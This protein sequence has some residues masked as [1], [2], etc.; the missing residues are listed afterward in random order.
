[1][2]ERPSGFFGNFPCRLKYDSSFFAPPNPNWMPVTLHHK[3]IR[4][5][6]FHQLFQKE[7]ELEI[8]ADSL[9]L[10][11]E[12]REFLENKIRT[13]EKPIYGINTGFGQLCRKEVAEENLE[14]LQTNLVRSHACGIGAPVPE[15]I[16][17]LMLLLKIK[18]FT[19]GH[20]AISPELMETLVA[21]YNS[22]AAPVVF[23][24]GSLGASGD[25]VPLAHMTLPL[26]G[27]GEVL[28]KN[29]RISGQDFLTKTGHPPV[30][31]KAKEGL[32]MLNGTQFMLAYGLDLVWR[33]ERVMENAMAVCALAM[34]AYD[35]RIDSLDPAIHA[36][37]PHKG[38]IRVAEKLSAFLKDS[39]IATKEKHQVQDPYSFRCLP[40]VL[41]ASWDTLDYVS[42]VLE[43]ELN[44]ITDN[45]LVFKESG[46][47]ISGGNFHG[48]PLALALDFLAI[49][50][51][52]VANIAERML[53]QILSGERGLPV[54]LTKNPGL[55]SGFMIP[56]YSAA[57]LVS[58]NKQLSTPASVDS[59]V[60]SNGQE[61]H[62]SMGA[63]AALKGS[64]VLDNVESVL[65]ILLLAAA[66]AMDFRRPMKT[67]PVLEKWLAD[68][69]TKVPFRSSDSVF[70]P[71][72][73]TAI[74]FVRT[75]QIE[76]YAT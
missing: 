28:W 26:L 61:D 49:A 39:Q 27:E 67:S 7:G 11:R 21:Y 23:E 3:Y 50:M 31:L 17:R 29:Q 33:S 2:I 55:E 48:Q 38:Q 4:I 63:N 14:L 15:R 72:L 70:K 46:K 54:F 47:V 32:A 8:S 22:G 68:F 5:Q 9:K 60:S 30:K 19:T 13:S 52:E 45:P 76:D 16:S 73:D 6:E 1:L 65:G 44:S 35:S 56:Q 74:E 34:D 51:A 10:I 62:V 57:S 18:S 20:S 58:Q 42:S 69:R 66:Q 25:L 40:Q 64:K 24:Q 41:G 75:H 53:F 43:T 59:I 36:V 12:S 37:R 71:D